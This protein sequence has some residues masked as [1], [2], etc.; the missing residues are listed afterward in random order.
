[1]GE[2]QRNSD[3]SEQLIRGGWLDRLTNLGMWAAALGVIVAFGLVNYG[4][5]SR[6]IFNVSPTWVDDTVGYLLIFIV[7]AASAKNLYKAQHLYVD[8]LTSY[9]I[10]NKPSWQ[11]YFDLWAQSSVLLFCSI[12]IYTSIDSIRV[13][14]EFGLTTTDNLQV[15]VYYLLVLI[16]LGAIFMGCVSITNLLK[17]LNQMIQGK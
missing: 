7:M 4:V 14:A 5:V 16:L 9:L 12:M 2:E 10:K 13:S 6:Y 15:P 11:I 17:R 8:I 3:T 1:M